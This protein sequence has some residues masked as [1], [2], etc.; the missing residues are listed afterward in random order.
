[1]NFAGVQENWEM[2]T[3]EVVMIDIPFKSDG[4]GERGYV[5]VQV[6]KAVLIGF[7][8]RFTVVLEV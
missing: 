6:G 8:G 3:L 1:M 5:K 4:K 2:V 7:K